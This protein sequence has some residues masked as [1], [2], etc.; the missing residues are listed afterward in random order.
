MVSD[1]TKTNVY[2]TASGLLKFS[3]PM[4]GDGIAINPRKHIL[5]TARGYNFWDTRTGEA[6]KAVH[7]GTM[8]WPAFS[9]DGNLIY[10]Y[11][12]LWALESGEKIGEWDAP[13]P[14]A[15]SHDGRFLGLPGTVWDL[16]AGSP[17][18]KDDRRPPPKQDTKAIAFSPDD[19]F[20]ITARFDGEIWIR[21]STTGPLVNRFRADEAVLT[22]AISTDRRRI[23]TIGSREPV[24]LWRSGLREVRDGE[25]P[26]APQ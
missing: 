25:I 22:M 15:F 14:A 10:T 16:K 2:D 19:L 13:D 1:E 4:N 17:M 26:G 12:S 18:W 11:R 3:L 6:M 20:L 7:G 5:V 24:K 23:A 9:P 8:D 21:E